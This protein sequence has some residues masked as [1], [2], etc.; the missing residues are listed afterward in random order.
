MCARTKVPES[1]RRAENVLREYGLIGDDERVNPDMVCKEVTD[2]H[3]GIY[4]GVNGRIIARGLNHGL[5][6]SGCIVPKVL[7]PEAPKPEPKL[8]RSTGNVP[9]R[10]SPNRRP[11]SRVNFD[12]L[13]KDLD[14]RPIADRIFILKDIFD[15][16][17]DERIQVVDHFMKLSK[18]P[19]HQV[20]NQSELAL[21]YFIAR[22]K[23]VL[24]RWLDLDTDTR[25]RVLENATH[26]MPYRFIYNETREIWRFPEPFDRYARDIIGLLFN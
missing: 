20:A 2:L 21:V 6:S 22:D 3:A 26:L 4:D 5:R 9:R 19:E 10:P 11:H 12:R 17:P 13:V 1:I 15:N 8:A 25:E 24:E 23:S 16:H 7:A 18:S 14:G